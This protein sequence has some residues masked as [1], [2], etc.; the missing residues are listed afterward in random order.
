[1]RRGTTTATNRATGRTATA[2]PLTIAFSRMITITTIP[3]SIPVVWTDIGA[4]SAPHQS[5]PFAMIVH[6]QTFRTREPRWSPT[7][8]AAKSSPINPNGFPERGY[9]ASSPGED[10]PDLLTHLT[11]ELGAQDSQPPHGRT[12]GPSIDEMVHAQSPRMRSAAPR[13]LPII[14]FQTGWISR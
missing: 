7:A 6:P 8:R 10:L 5:L 13:T 14:G 2:T 1:M 11:A 9:C 12:V 3:D 4:A